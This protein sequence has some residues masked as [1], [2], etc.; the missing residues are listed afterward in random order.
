MAATRTDRSS[1]LTIADCKSAVYIGQRVT[2]TKDS[3]KKIKGVVEKKLPYLCLI[4]LDT[5]LKNGDT[6]VTMDY[7]EVYSQKAAEIKQRAY[8]EEMTLD[9]SLSFLLKK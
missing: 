7:F 8:S 1:Q 5:P 6:T 2:F 9:E 4:K 3:G